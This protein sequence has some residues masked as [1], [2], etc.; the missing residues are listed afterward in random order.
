MAAESTDGRSPGGEGPWRARIDELEALLARAE[1]ARDEAAGE[2]DLLR[3]VLDCA[4]D[5][6][7]IHDRRGQH[8]FVSAGACR[9]LGYTREELL[10]LSVPGIAP[11][12][13]EGF[14]SRAWET[15]FREGFVRVEG[16]HRRKDGTII[17]VEV[18][19]SPLHQADRPLVVAVARDITRR[20]ARAA[21]LRES[22]QR[23]RELAE[24]MQDGVYTADA[25]G[26]VTYV[27][28]VIERR[29][30]IPAEDF[31]GRD[32]L[33]LVRPEDR[34]RGRENLRRALAGEQ[35]HP[36]EISYD[37]GGGQRLVVEVNLSPIVRDG[38]VVGVL[39]VSRDVT[40][41]RQAE[42]EI[43]RLNA[44]LRRRVAERTASRDQTEARYRFLFED[45]LAAN[46]VV[47][48][49]GRIVEANRAFAHAL[50]YEREELTGRPSEELFVP[51]DRELARSYHEMN[52]RGETVGRAVELRM[53]GRQSVRTFLFA[54]GLAEVREG[55]RLIGLLISAIDVTALRRASEALAAAHRKATIAAENERRHVAR[56]LHDSLGQSL[57]ALKLAVQTAKAAYDA[58]DEE[59]VRRTLGQAGQTSAHM[60]AEVR[61]I[62]YG[63]YPPALESLGLAAAVKQLARTVQPP[64]EVDVSCDV[65]AEDV[66]L[67]PE[68][69]IAVFRVVQEALR[70]ALAHSRAGRVTLSLSAPANRL[71][72][73]VV[74]DGTGFDVDARRD[75]LGL[76]T[77]RE[78]TAAAGGRLRIASRPGRT[79]VRAD[80]P[81]GSQIAEEA[82]PPDRA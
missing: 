10:A 69:E 57:V 15:A 2:A 11:D 61:S 77:M 63:L 22:E 58:G 9:M 44:R 49:D 1:H 36:F 24:A 75:G 74:D 23:Y 20:L 62:C 48:P 67:A 7:Y 55:E 4:E 32:V 31:I 27:N 79:E 26:R 12:F 38:E 41:R 16:Q 34:P 40:E 70:N 29:S 81:R 43:R 76:T 71:V 21:A 30:G 28:G 59:G 56:E 50:G 18:S 47:A 65:E 54:P 46:A 39:G 53:L 60:I 73:S 19:A 8:V 35:V 5:A 64:P 33:A 45:G 6:V 17:P 37:T 82:W 51:E 52:L 78:R 68:A 14:Y 25:E 80:V 72:V 13:E 66:R 42:E 3:G